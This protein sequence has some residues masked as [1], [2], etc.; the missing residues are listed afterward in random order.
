VIVD[1]KVALGIFTPDQAIAF[2]QHN[3]PMD[4]AD[5]REEVVEM[6]ELPGQK[7]SYQTGKLQIMQM[8]Q[9]AQL[10]QR[11]NFNVESFHN[12]M[13]L[14]GNLPIA[15]LRWE[16]LGLDDDVNRLAGLN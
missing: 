10:N 14:N 11:D 15:L 3:V 1:V 13:W 2:L 16:H 6:G 9:D 4:A 5:A 12:Y 7:I 8:L